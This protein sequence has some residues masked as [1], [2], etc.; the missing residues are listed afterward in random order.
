ML[1]PGIKYLRM[2]VEVVPET[3]RM[4]TVEEEIYK[5]T[6]WRCDGKDIELFAHETLD[7]AGVLSELLN[8]YRPN[9]KLSDRP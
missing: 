7:G 8:G 2:L 4:G 9:P 3:G 1:H 5:S 6:W